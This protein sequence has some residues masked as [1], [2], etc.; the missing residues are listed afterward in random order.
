MILREAAGFVRS[1]RGV[2]TGDYTNFDCALRSLVKAARLDGGY[3]RLDR[4]PPQI[5]LFAQQ[6]SEPAVDHPGL[7]MLEA[8]PQRES[9]FYACERNVVDWCGK[10]RTVLQELYDQFC[11]IGGDLREYI[12]YFHRSDVAPLWCWKAFSQVKC[13]GGFSTVSKKA[14]GQQRKL[15]M[16][17][18]FNYLMTDVRARAGIGM[19][20]G[21]A[22]S[23]LR[24]GTQGFE[25][26]VCDQSNSF[27]SVI[28]PTWMIEYQATPPVAA[29]HVWSLLPAG[30][31]ATLKPYSLVSAC[32]R[33]LA[34]G[35]AHAVFILMAINLRIIGQVLR[36]PLVNLGN[37]AGADKPQF[38]LDAVE[39][40]FWQ[41][42]R[43]FSG[44]CRTFVVLLLV[45]GDV[46]TALV[47]RSVEAACNALE[48]PS[49]IFCLRLGSDAGPWLDSKHEAAAIHGLLSEGIDC[50]VCVHAD[51]HEQHSRDTRASKTSFWETPTPSCP[52]QVLNARNYTL[53]QLFLY[54][55]AVHAGGGAFWIISTNSQLMDTT[56]ARVL[57]D[58]AGASHVS[59]TQP[60]FLHRPC[61]SLSNWNM[62]YL[63]THV[64]DDPED[65]PAQLQLALQHFRDT[66]SG[67]TGS[68]LKP[69]ARFP[70]YT[71]STAC[72]E[73]GGEGVTIL[74]E[75]NERGGH[76]FLGPKNAAVYLHVDDS[77]TFSHPGSACYADQLMEAIANG[78]ERWGFLVPDRQPHGVLEKAVGYAILSGRGRGR[79]TLP[80]KKCLQ[81]R[82]V[83]F[84]LAA[85]RFINT[86]VLKCIL[87]I[88]MFGAQL[89]RDLMPIPH[90]S[91]KL[92]DVHPYATVTLWNTV[93]AELVLMGNLLPLM[94]ADTATPIPQYVC[95][96][97]AMGAGETGKHDKGGYGAVIGA[98]T[99]EEGKQILQLG[100]VVGRTVAGAGDCRKGA[101]RPDRLLMA[102]VPFTRVPATLF[103][104][105]RW[106]C[107]CAGRWTWED[108][109][110]LGE[111]R[112]VIKMLNVLLQAPITHGQF[113]INFEDNMPVS[114]AFSK[115]RSAVWAFNMLCRR[116]AAL[117]LAGGYRLLLPWVETSL[118][119]ADQLSRDI[120]V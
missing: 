84:G 16:Q 89:R 67:P 13:V 113:V 78:M 49:K 110:T 70:S 43:L 114:G 109:I 85:K 47:R 7:C 103:H 88:Y 93:R 42:R 12:A 73:T 5:P 44:D 34:M 120:D 55:G 68:L 117:V 101:K 31:R 48:A 102:T 19:N 76:A 86:E 59:Q 111:G 81:L 20:G 65:V 90:A 40:I 75:L 41:C 14:A 116:K 95:A 9:A 28:V 36:S 53:L 60:E 105:S 80:I 54:G 62:L 58:S 107:L 82:C 23:R 38:N 25:A 3:Y 45:V 115:G 79:F 35:S 96:S 108:H 94:F 66:I 2:P 27:T 56:E 46:S 50:L 106:H 4:R 98:L 21:G 83:F 91:Y 100:E 64:P 92:V 52:S 69:G 11:F 1:R 15:L 32:Y 26:A 8:L 63:Q 77:V 33:R 30:L 97:D 18:P 72:P 6:I 37:T 22:V 71:Y 104:P 118:Q 99:E 74:N 119:P 29:A 57:Q 39:T 10:S 17:V 61:W 112:A 51:D 87:G 24:S